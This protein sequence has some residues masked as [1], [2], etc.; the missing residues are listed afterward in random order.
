MLDYSSESVFVFN[1]LIFTEIKYRWANA[2]FLKLILIYMS[3]RIKNMYNIQYNAT[4]SP[5][6]Y[7]FL[8]IMTKVHSTY[9]KLYS[10]SYHFSILVLQ[11]FV[12]FQPVYTPIL[13]FS[14]LFVTIAQELT[15]FSV[16][17]N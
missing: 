17:L 2:G 13:I 4:K 10:H 9:I 6:L 5:Y 16:N 12:T 3:G 7:F 1:K 11:Y 14:K 8:R 15:T